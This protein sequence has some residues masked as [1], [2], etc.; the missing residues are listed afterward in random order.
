MTEPTIRILCVDDH[1][2]VREGIG[3]VIDRERDM[4]VVAFAATAV[5]ALQQFRITQPDVTLMDLRLRSEDGT[6]AIQRILAE[7][8]TARIIVLTMYEGDEDIY[9]AL[10]AGAVAYL[11]KDTLSDD[12]IGTIREVHAGIR[13]VR[14]EISDRLADRSLHPSLTPRELGVL[15]LLATGKRN[16][17]IAYD[18]NISE[19]TVQVHMKNIF[20]KLHVND[21][22]GAIHVA[23]RRGII[24]LN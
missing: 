8:P 12:L 16:K 24:H 14:K 11:L 5:E 19:A 10:H 22:T 6:S 18:L 2:I 9:R 3:L 17:E 23:A 13:S 21:R 15:E 1:A 7:S 4:K 20:F